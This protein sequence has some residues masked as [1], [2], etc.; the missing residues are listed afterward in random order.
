V[1]GDLQ[2]VDFL[3]AG[4]EVSLENATPVP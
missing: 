2:D 1:L 4:A 3:I